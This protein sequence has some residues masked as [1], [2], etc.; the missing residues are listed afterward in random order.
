MLSNL[1]PECFVTWT[2]RELCGVLGPL[3]LV[4]AELPGLCVFS[5][6]ST[7]FVSQIV[8]CKPEPED[9]LSEIQNSPGSQDEDS[10]EI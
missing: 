8:T 4:F 2:V 9:C 5:T 6:H 7:I 1:T 3:L 10:S